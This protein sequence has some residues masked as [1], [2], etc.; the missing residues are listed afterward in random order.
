MPIAIIA[1]TDEEIRSGKGRLMLTR[2]QAAARLGVAERR[3]SD[4]VEEGE[5]TPFEERLFHIPL[6][7]ADEVEEL[8]KKRLKRYF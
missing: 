5:I 3:I 8:R 1:G 2:T 6:F 7:V 4:L